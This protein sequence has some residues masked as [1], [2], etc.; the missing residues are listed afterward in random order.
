[1][2]RKSQAQRIEDLSSDIGGRFKLSTLIIK[3]MREYYTGG[4]TFMPKVRNHDELFD[5]V[6]DQ[7]ESKEI[8]LKKPREVSSNQAPGSGGALESEPDIVP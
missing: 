1:M 2:S 7:I 4:R 8:V 3:R 5:L 6:L